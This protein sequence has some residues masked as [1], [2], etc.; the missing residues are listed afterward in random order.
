MWRRPVGRSPVRIILLEDILLLIDGTKL[1]YLPELDNVRFQIPR[2]A[3]SHPQPSP[4]DPHGHATKS[5]HGRRQNRNPSPPL[6]QKAR[7]GATGHMKTKRCLS[8]GANGDS[9]GETR[10]QGEAV[11]EMEVLLVV[12]AQTVGVHHIAVLVL[13][14]WCVKPAP[15]VKF[16]YSKPATAL[17]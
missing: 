10:T 9:K 13:Q 4:L 7:V 1:R 12:G 16:L 11:K 6:A 5:D 8:C 17:P 15:R 14:S 2:H 3:P